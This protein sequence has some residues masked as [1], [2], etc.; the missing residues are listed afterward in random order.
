MFGKLSV[1]SSVLVFSLN[2]IEKNH[3]HKSSQT[4]T[5]ARKMADSNGNWSLL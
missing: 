4:A 3:F 1:F 2:K 5:A